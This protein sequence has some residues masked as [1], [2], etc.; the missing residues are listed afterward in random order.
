MATTKRMPHPPKTQ[1]GVAQ[2]IRYITNPA[3]TTGETAV[4]V[5]SQNCAVP[6]AAQEFMECRERWGK[7]GG[8]YAYH[9]EQSFAPGEATPE[10]VYQCGVELAQAMFGDEYQVVLA[11]H[12]DKDHLH[13]HF[14]VCAVSLKDGHKLQTDHEFLRRLR[15]ESDRICREHGLSVVENPKG[16]G[17]SYAEWILEKNG[18]FTWRG[19][20]REDIDALLPQAASLK[21][22]LD[23][24]KGRG[25]AVKDGKYLALSPPGNDRFFRLYKL[26]SGYAPEE[27]AARFTGRRYLPPGSQ[28]ILHPRV[29]RARLHGTFRQLRWLGGLTGQYYVYLYRLRKIFG[30]PPHRQMRYPIHCRKDA[31]QVREFAADL[32]LL[33]QHGIRTLSELGALVSAL[34][35]EQSVLR[36]GR[37]ALRVELA[38]AET[39]EQMME[40]QK[41]IADTQ[42]RLRDLRDNLK[43]CERIYERS[44][45][46]RDNQKAI[47]QTESTDTEKG[48][49][50]DGSRS[51]SGGD[52]LADRYAGR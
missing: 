25:Y 31:R 5:G 17:K 6:T 36:R 26:G 19:Q 35:D 38:K 43:A 34:L 15:R 33:S 24:L 42:S 9:F 32:R 52:P 29:Q 37:E 11:T 1:Q 44:R 13:N 48:L 47:I 51:R 50:E 20:I 8:N 7:T 10:E 18:G 30:Q 45:T 12:L 14:A 3:K 41:K 21:E 16:E 4:F 46:I 2:L 39:P 28:R 27:L 40:L 49:M 22:L 23:L